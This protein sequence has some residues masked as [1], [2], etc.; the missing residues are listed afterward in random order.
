MN[1]DIKI[2]ATDVPSHGFTHGGS[3]H[4]DDVFSTALLKLLNPDFSWQRGNEV[5]EDF[6]GIVYDIGGGAYDHHQVDARVRENGVP[7]AAFG[8]LWEK[9]GHVFL[10]KKSAEAFDEEF[11]QEIDLTDNTGKRNPLSTVI[12][13]MNPEW[14]ETEEVDRAFADAVEYAMTTL[15]AMLRHFQAIDEAKNLVLRKIPEARNRVLELD[16]YM[17]WLEALRETEIDY[18]IYPSNRGGFNVQVVPHSSGDPIVD[19]TTG[20]LQEWRGRRGE[21][22]E[23]M[24][25]IEGFN[26]CHRAGFLC[27]VDT[28]EGAWKIIEIMNCNR[29]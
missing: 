26:F 10:E 2:N 28:L 12:R 18:V 9:Y 22:L 4:A 1:K 20:F 25:G 17:P 14:N 23:K 21:D 29:R 3:F 27:S 24:T 16:R 5:P 8:L 13:S 6:V 7:Y 11:V 15:C 19:D